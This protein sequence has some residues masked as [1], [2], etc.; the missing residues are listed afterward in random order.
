[1]A[2][3]E[4]LKDGLKQE[5]GKFGAGLAVGALKEAGVIAK[6]GTISNCV[7]SET[8]ATIGKGAAAV[9]AG[10]GPIGWIA[11][12]IIGAYLLWDAID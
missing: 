6:N 3:M 10:A 4:E 12:G 9:L 8:M 1:M 5:Q 2:I 7:N 11:T